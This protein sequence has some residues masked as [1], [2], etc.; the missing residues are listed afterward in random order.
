MQALP[1]ITDDINAAEQ[2]RGFWT[3]SDQSILQGL[4]PLFPV[5]FRDPVTFDKCL[6]YVQRFLKLKL[7]SDLKVQT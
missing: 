5:V 3:L 6:N 1:A 2:F 7:I 4:H